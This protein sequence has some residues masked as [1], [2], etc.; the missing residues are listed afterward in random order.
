[1]STANEKLLDKITSMAVAD[2]AA[3][4]KVVVDMLVVVSSKDGVILDN[5][6][7]KRLAKK[8]VFDLL[9][10][11]LRTMSS[12]D[13]VL[14][15]E[16]RAEMLLNAMLKSLPQITFTAESLP[17]GGYKVVTKLSGKEIGFFTFGLIDENTP[18]DLLRAGYI[19]VD[20]PFRKKKL[21]LGMYDYAAA[22]AKSEGYEG[23]YSPKNQRLD[24]SY[25]GPEVITTEL[26]KAQIAQTT[27]QTF[28]GISSLSKDRVAEIVKTNAF[29]MGEDSAMTLDEMFSELIANK[30]TAVERALK[31]GV[32]EG[33]SEN[34]I[35][36]MLRGTRAAGFKDG[37]LDYDRRNV[38]ALAR[39]MLNSISNQVASEFYSQNNDII[40]GLRWTSTLDGRTSA[41]CRSRDGEIFPVN[42]GPRPPAHIRC[43][44]FMVPV[45]KSWREL[46]IPVDDMPA[47]TRASMDGQ[48]PEELTY[49]DWLKT[50][51][52]GFIEEVLGPAR[53]ELF[54]SGKADMSDFVNDR[55]HTLTLDQLKHLLT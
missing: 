4:N 46:G 55:G 35:M 51:P 28:Y 14:F 48:V 7:M 39:T 5:P 11:K 33:K 10:E 6:Q 32:I 52:K 24:Q 23:I 27:M 13:F 2:Q 40:K 31:L 38:E 43:R 53:A 34:D 44:S 42:A 22:H 8:K 20:K 45:V 9:R 25:D 54:M 41:V 47:S 29:K 17:D 19:S 30:K 12:G 18:A 21:A 15:A 26:T 49:G 50:K 1:M 16:Y 36:Q 3:A 37:I